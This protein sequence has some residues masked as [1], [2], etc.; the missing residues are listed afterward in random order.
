MGIGRGIA[1]LALGAGH[2][3]A[4]TAV[5]DTGYSMS[6]QCPES[7]PTKEAREE[8]VS[9]FIAWA[10]AAHPDWTIEQFV[11]YRMKLLVAH[12]CTATLEKIRENAVGI[13][14]VPVQP[15]S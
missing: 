1:L 11:D 2:A 7:L 5:P 12:K 8:A 15:S 14:S 13:P 3:N 6:F 9:K 10:Q 4:Q